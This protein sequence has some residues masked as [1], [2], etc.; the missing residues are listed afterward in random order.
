MSHSVIGMTLLCIIHIAFIIWGLISAGSSKGKCERLHFPTASA[1]K[2]LVD[3]QGTLAK[4]TQRMTNELAN[5]LI[6]VGRKVFLSG[7]L[8]CA[9]RETGFGPWCS[10]ELWIQQWE[11]ALHC[12]GSRGV[13]GPSL[14]SLPE[15]QRHARSVSRQ[16][17]LEGRLLCWLV[18]GVENMFLSIWFWLWFKGF[19]Q[20]IHTFNYLLYPVPERR[21]T[22][23]SWSLSKLS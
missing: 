10:A 17:N 14:H 21:V 16:P 1:L 22:R 15:L 8:W 12:L 23:V 6:A 3:P 9:G 18:L 13:S 2:T 7:S 11:S 19:L 4:S 20:V 5:T